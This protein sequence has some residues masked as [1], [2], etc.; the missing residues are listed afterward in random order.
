ME[1]FYLVQLLSEPTRVTSNSSTLIDHIIT[2]KL[3]STLRMVQICGVSD[4]RVQIANFD[5][6]PLHARPK[7]YQIRAFRKC[8][9]DRICETL[10]TAPWH[11]M[12]KALHPTQPYQ[13]PVCLWPLFYSLSKLFS[14]KMYRQLAL[15]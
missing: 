15:C 10:H 8:D 1:D 7:V 2:T 12:S 6:S 5:Y 9:W 4:Y 13:A 14:A 11:V 3:T